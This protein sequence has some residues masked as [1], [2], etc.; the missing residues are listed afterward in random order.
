ME[1]VSEGLS[2][3]EDQKEDDEA[4]GRGSGAVKELSKNKF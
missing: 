4:R 1:N 3:R 2:F